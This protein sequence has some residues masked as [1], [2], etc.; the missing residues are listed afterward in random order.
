MMKKIKIGFSS[1]CPS[2]D[3]VIALLQ[4]KFDVEVLDENYD[5]FLCME[6]IYNTKDGFLELINQKPKTIRIFF[7]GEAIYPDLNL[8]DYAICFD[9]FDKSR[10]L[11]FPQKLFWDWLDEELS[12]DDAKKNVNV[13]D[14]LKEK[15]KFCNFIYSNALSHPT[16]DKLF[17]A[18]SKYKKVD[19]LGVHLKNTTIEDTR[20]T[21]NWEKISVELKKPYKFSIAA[22]NAQFKDYTTEKIITSM[23]ANTIPIYFGNPEV[24]KLYNPKSFINVND[25]SC[26]NDVV[27]RVKEI[28]K[29]DDLYLEI[30]SQPWRTEQQIENVNKEYQE[31][32]TKFYNIFEQDFDKAHRRPQGCWADFYYPAFFQALFDDRYLNRGAK[33][34]KFI[35][36]VFS[37]K[38]DPDKK[39][40]N[41]TILGKTMKFKRIKR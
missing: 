30:M 17:Y 6:S 16:R 22:E 39:H 33:N 7:C 41:I 8:F 24:A 20:Y 18:L 12:I 37:V 25:F 2:K 40:K 3:L 23:A 5:Y 38:N 27:K 34:D 21:K 31:Y 26:L 4:K 15:T 13:K 10:I 29:N 28:D 19:S 11:K 9:E 36:K 32:L 1:N 35:E 14:I